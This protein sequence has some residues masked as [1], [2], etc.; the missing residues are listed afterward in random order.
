MLFPYYCLDLIVFL[1]SRLC[2]LS[3][4]PIPY[5]FPTVLLLLH[6]PLDFQTHIGDNCLPTAAY[7]YSGGH[8]D[9]YPFLCFYFQLLFYNIWV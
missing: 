5:F 7:I 8:N 3:S 1:A 2:P 4:P 9:S 6:S